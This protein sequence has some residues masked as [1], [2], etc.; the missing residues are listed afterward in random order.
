MQVRT[1]FGIFALDNDEIVEFELFPKN[2]DS[3]VKYYL[4][5]P[6]LLRGK[7]AG[8]E[9]RELALKYGFVSSKEEYESLLHE[10]NI[11]IA[12]KQAAQVTP[13][14]QIIATIEAVDDLNETCNILAERLREWY[15]LSYNEKL[16]GEELA[17][18]IIEMQND[19]EE[20]RLMQSFASSLLG[21]Y[22]SCSY[23][24]NYLKENMPK[25]AP[26]ITNIAGYML[27]ARLLSI[28]GSLEKLAS[29]PSSTVQVI[30]AGNALFKHLKG[31]ATSPKHG[32]IFQHTLV[33]SAPKKLRGKIARALALK[34]SL[35]AK[36]DYYSGELKEDLREELNNR[37]EEIKKQHSRY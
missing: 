12:K 32:I 33:N 2:L 15:M 22:R 28:A 5:E 36:Y 19:N 6:L 17:N 29:M 27:G 7:V 26:N 16:R 35:A 9:L 18:R 10:L 3:I 30:G 25:T 4:K 24:E 8:V 1:W 34:I 11:A 13:E 23:I 31:K 20:I 37:V 14:K 21:L